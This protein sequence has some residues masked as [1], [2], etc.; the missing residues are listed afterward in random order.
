MVQRLQADAMTDALVGVL[1]RTFLRTFPHTRAFCVG[2]ESGAWIFLGSTQPFT[3][4]LALL[5]E[6]CA[7]PSVRA[8]LA[9][10]GVNDA[11]ALL[12]FEAISPTHVAELC[13]RGTRVNTDD[14]PLLELEG[15]QAFFAARRS[16]LLQNLDE[17]RGQRDGLLIEALRRSEPAQR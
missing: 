7:A 2:G 6:R 8:D 17:R 4:N 11:A 9:T 15:P 13:A 10:I 1:A 12:G 14:L 3:P 16:R 5:E